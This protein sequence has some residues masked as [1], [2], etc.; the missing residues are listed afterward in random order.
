MHRIF[1]LQ[2]K[3]YTSQRPSAAYVAHTV[4][5]AAYGGAC[6]EG[7]VSTCDCPSVGGCDARKR[8][9]SQSGRWRVSSLSMG[10]K[11]P[12]CTCRHSPCSMGMPPQL[13]ALLAEAFRLSRSMVHQNSPL[14]SDA[15]CMPVHLLSSPSYL[16]H[17]PHPPP[18]VCLPQ[19]PTAVCLGGADQRS[20]VRQSA[21]RLPHCWRSITKW[22]EDTT[23]CAVHKRHTRHHGI[24]SVVTQPPARRWQRCHVR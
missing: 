11:R 23:C 8:F 1:S 16:P 4:S 3:P 5:T 2:A 10:T 13:V 7:H 18:R 12:P 14:Q 20:G 6:G 21:Q 15:S 17:P 22:Q 24:R 19:P 9:A